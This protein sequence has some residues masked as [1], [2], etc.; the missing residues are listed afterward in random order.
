MGRYP[1]LPDLDQHIVKRGPV[2]GLPVNGLQGC[3]HRTHGGARL[4]NI[5]G[6]LIE[7]LAPAEDHQQQQDGHKGDV[8]MIGIS[9]GE[10][11]K[12]GRPALGL[13]NLMRCA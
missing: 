13:T 7:P 2:C 8:Q 11:L 6:Q 9:V 5:E 3:A 1:L 12:S 4:V 10:T